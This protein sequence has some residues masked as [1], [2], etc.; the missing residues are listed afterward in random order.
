MCRYPKAGVQLISLLDH[1]SLRVQ[2]FAAEALGRTMEKDAINPLIDLLIRNNG[3]DP[4]LRH[5][6]T[7]A[8]ARIGEPTSLK[9]L[10]NHNSRAIRISAVVALRRM[11]DP[12]VAEFLYDQDELVV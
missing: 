10:K 4:W 6:A 2:F 5:G 7:L 8:L 9:K 3:Q 12:G 11:A 1:S